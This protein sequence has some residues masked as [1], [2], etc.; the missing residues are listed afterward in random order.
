M[1]ATH[2]QIARNLVAKAP[3]GV[4]ARGC[5]DVV[6]LGDYST[7]ERMLPGVVF[8]SRKVSQ[9]EWELVGTCADGSV[10]VWRLG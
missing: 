3:S 8:A 2:A 6:N 5:Q 7:L 9:D 4:F 1:A 10:C